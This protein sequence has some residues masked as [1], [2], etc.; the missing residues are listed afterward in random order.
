MKIG[1]REGRSSDLAEVLRMIKALALFENEPNAVLTTV[2]SMERD[3]A[4]GAFGF[5]VAEGD[6]GGCVG[7]ALYHDRYST[8]C[9]DQRV[10]VEI[11]TPHEQDGALLVS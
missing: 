10:S 1:V 4:A 3:F 9:V 5:F 8:W 7:F 6:G 2:D 11:I